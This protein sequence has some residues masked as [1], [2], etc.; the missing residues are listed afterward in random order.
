AYTYAVELS[1]DEAVAAGAAALQFTQAVILYVESFLR[2]PVGESV[3]VG[4]YDR[5]RSLWV[6][7]SNGRIIKIVSRTAGLADL[8]SDGDGLADSAAVLA[9]LGI[10][11]AERQRLAS[12][13]QNGQSLWR[14]P[15]THFSAWDANWGWGP[16]ADAEDPNQPDPTDDGEVDDPSCQSSSIIECQNQTLG[17]VVSS[18]GTPFNLHYRSDRVP[19]R[20]AA[21]T[22]QIP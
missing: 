16:P 17:G 9:A 13:Y 22:L 14:L 2:F 19:G 3:P 1:A 8:D 11:D 6:P 5:D 10:S 4:Y 20:T 21:N 15:I 7:A 12:L 18:V